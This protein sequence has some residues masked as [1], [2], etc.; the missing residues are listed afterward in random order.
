LDFYGAREDN[1][2]TPT[3]RLGA[4]P[5]GLTSAN[6]NQHPPFF[7]PDTLPV[8]TLPLYPGL[9]LAPNHQICWLA[10]PVAW[11]ASQHI[12]YV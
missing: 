2:D 9:V 5:S 11:Y 10:Y 1:R 3:I 8:A 6:I 4:T 12:W 7:M